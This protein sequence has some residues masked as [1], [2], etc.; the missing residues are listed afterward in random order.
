MGYWQINN[1]RR[2]YRDNNGQWKRDR[3]VWVPTKKRRVFN[4]PTN[5]LRR[6]ELV[7]NWSLGN[8]TGGF[9]GRTKCIGLFPD[10]KTSGNISQN[11]PGDS[12]GEADA[13][14]AIVLLEPN[15]KAP[16]GYLEEFPNDPD[17]AYRGFQETGWNWKLE[18]VPPG[19]QARVP[20]PIFNTR[21]EAKNFIQSPP[22]AALY[23]GNGPIPLGHQLLTG[24]DNE[25]D[26]DGYTDS[27]VWYD[28]DQP[29]RR[30]VLFFNI[31]QIAAQNNQEVFRF[32]AILDATWEDPVTGDTTAVQ[33]TM[34]FCIY[35]RPFNAATDVSPTA[36]LVDFF[37]TELSFATSDD[38][39][40]D[41]GQEIS[42]NPWTMLVYPNNYQ[43]GSEEDCVERS[44]TRA[45]PEDSLFVLHE[46]HWGW[47]T[48]L[49]GTDTTN[50]ANFQVDKAIVFRTYQD[51]TG[52]NTEIIYDYVN[53][54]DPLE[55]TT[56]N[57]FVWPPNVTQVTYEHEWFVR[58]NRGKYARV[59]T[60]VIYTKDG[61]P[62][63]EPQ[64]QPWLDVSNINPFNNEANE[65]LENPPSPDRT[66]LTTL[67]FDTEQGVPKISEPIVLRANDYAEFK[68]QFPDGIVRFTWGLPQ[69]PPPGLTITEALV[70]TDS[71]EFRLN[72]DGA[73]RPNPEY[74]Y[75]LNVTLTYWI[76]EEAKDNILPE[77][78]IAQIPVAFDIDDKNVA[79]RGNYDKE[80]PP[81]NDDPPLN[82]KV[83]QK[84]LLPP[85]EKLFF[86]KFYS[87]DNNNAPLKVATAGYYQAG[88]PNFTSI[89]II[90]G[91]GGPDPKPVLILPYWNNGA[92][93]IPAAIK[94]DTDIAA[95]P[96][97]AAILDKGGKVTGPN[98]SKDL[99]W[100]QQ[101][102]GA[103]LLAG[104]T[105]A[106]F[107]SIL[108]PGLN[109]LE[110]E[111]EIPK[112]DVFPSGLLIT[113]HY[114]EYSNGLRSAYWPAGD[115]FEFS[116]T[117]TVPE[118]KTSTWGE[119]AL[120]LVNLNAATYI[121][122]IPL[123]GVVAGTVTILTQGGFRIGHPDAEV[124]DM[125]SFARTPTFNTAEASEMLLDPDWYEVDGL[126]LRT[127]VQ[128][129]QGGLGSISGFRALTYDKNLD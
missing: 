94:T 39:A 128:K 126:F 84:D 36:E 72:Y 15:P 1:N 16:D 117:D 114:S 18:Y 74:Q 8:N 54:I 71:A 43:D 17:A 100:V 91:P 125:E 62:T 52:A 105:L 26:W 34:P 60:T 107:Q 86:N 29:K 57:R 21:I 81:L 88:D 85:V 118:I 28:P 87:N 37:K 101:A 96:Q 22:W 68:A 44:F 12:Y 129:I 47:D 51:N 83:K 89:N 79:V 23:Q 48:G 70:G 6:P 110:F 127:K 10:N 76:N 63:N 32:E 9:E 24:D 4:D 3:S 58:D 82:T 31:E 122:K 109:L 73:D 59:C 112:T 56:Q 95:L 104:V 40:F 45:V 27:I 33:S 2:A 35:N 98:G 78:I 42:G 19:N 55:T 92:N 77:G 64:F 115:V 123:T 69:A 46:F 20:I 116:P 111:V 49:A 53:P 11:T 80:L 120:N 97:A 121:M 25:S 30:A 75:P 67:R 50:N 7:I 119:K 93:L 41:Q 103:W 102:D 13:W 108:N 124:G 113:R 99:T 66:F 38:P 65:F 5:A 90:R 14:N 61:P 106:N